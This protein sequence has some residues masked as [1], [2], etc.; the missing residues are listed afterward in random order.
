MM[1][2]IAAVLLLL[3]PVLAVVLVLAVPTVLG[4]VAYDVSETRAKKPASARAAETILGWP[5][6]A[7]RRIKLERGVARAFVIL[8]GVFWA[9]TAFAGLYTFR[10]TGALAA[11]FAASVPLIASLVTLIVGWYWERVASIML[12]VATLAVVYYSAVMGFELGVWVILGFFLI[13]P[14]LTAA[15][16]FW[17]A[18]RDY[19]ALVVFRLAHPEL[20]LAVA[21]TSAS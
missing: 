21:E 18:R 12:A 16:L 20:A 8:G 4:L 15:V 19:E 7:E 6:A 5:E 2:A 14:M 3:G 13:G 9:V 10:Q 11:F 17:L 1:I